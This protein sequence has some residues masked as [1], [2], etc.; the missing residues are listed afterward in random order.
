MCWS[1]DVYVANMACANTHEWKAK[2][3]T[4]KGKI[5]NKPK[6]PPQTE[7]NKQKPSVFRNIKCGS[8]G[9]SKDLEF[10]RNGNQCRS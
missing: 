10:F 7:N 1:I 6:P 3:Q 4:K 9:E 5:P 8:L 2:S